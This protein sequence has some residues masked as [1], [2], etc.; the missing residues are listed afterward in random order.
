MPILRNSC[1]QISMV[2]GIRLQKPSKKIQK[3]IYIYIV[4]T[5]CL[6]SRLQVFFK[7]TDP[8]LRGARLQL[9]CERCLK[10]VRK[11]PRDLGGVCVEI[12]RATIFVGC[13]IFS[14]EFWGTPNMGIVWE[15]YHYWGPIIGG[16]WNHPWFF[17]KACS[18]FGVDWQTVIFS[19]ARGQIKKASFWCRF[20]GK[21]P[22]IPECQP[23]SWYYLQTF[24]PNS[25]RKIHP[26]KWKNI[27]TKPLCS[28]SFVNLPVVL[29]FCHGGGWATSKMPELLLVLL[30]NR[31]NIYHVYASRYVSNVQSVDFP[32]KVQDT[33]D[34]RNPDHLGCIKPCK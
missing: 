14:M 17:F 31:P 13:L 10:K 7:T 22:T 19:E 30:A 5:F 3:N 32:M 12:Q 4:S 29:W 21:D 18:F 15:V 34:G 1:H 8:T 23:A 26:W 16:P 28:A 6:I 25:P 11:S 9:A 2:Y 27:W 20:C 24:A 33:V